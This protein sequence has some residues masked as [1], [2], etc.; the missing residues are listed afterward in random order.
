MAAIAKTITRVEQLETGDAIASG[1]VV[2]GSAVFIKN[3]ALV[4]HGVHGLVVY[5]LKDQ[6]PERLSGLM[7]VIKNAKCIDYHKAATALGL[8]HSMHSIFP[9]QSFRVDFDE[10]EIGAQSWQPKVDGLQAQFDA[11]ALVNSLDSERVQAFVDQLSAGGDA[12]QLIDAKVLVETTRATA[13]EGVN[14]S[15]IVAEVAARE[16]DVDSEAAAALGA[17]AAIQSDVDQNEADIAQEA[18]DRAAAVVAAIAAEVTARDGAISTAVAN[19]IDSAPGALD[20][21]NELAAALGDDAS[22]SASVTTS[23]AGK[24][25]QTAYL[26]AVNTAQRSL[27]NLQSLDTTTSIA[28]HLSDEQTRALAAEAVN[29]G[30][31]ATEQTRAQGVESTN[32]TA[33]SS[34]SAARATAVSGVQS[35]LDAVE[36]ILGNRTAVQIARVDASSSIQT[37]LDSKAADAVVVK[38][39]GNQTIVQNSTAAVLTLTNTNSDAPI[40]TCVGGDGEI[41]LSGGNV[42]ECDRPG[43]MYVR[44]S[45]G[46]GNVT[47][48]SRGSSKVVC[49]DKVRLKVEASAE[50]D[51]TVENAKKV[52]FVEASANGSHFISLRAPDSVTASVE[53]ELPA[54]DGSAGQ[55]LKTDGNGALSFVTAGGLSAAANESI[56]GQWTFTESVIMEEPILRTPMAPINVVY[57]FDYDENNTDDA[58]VL[59]PDVAA[60][61]YGE[62]LNSAAKSYLLLPSVCPVGTR[63][64][65]YTVTGAAS[66]NKIY[67]GTENP[68]HKLF[69]QNST[70]RHNGFDSYASNAVRTSNNNN[71]YLIE[72][73]A[74]KMVTKITSDTWTI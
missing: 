14:A 21:L 18:V 65:I 15:A 28:T 56:S 70:T 8:N 33:I 59:S 30:L 44:A 74:K 46:S 5:K 32:A 42:I 57:A 51:F 52:K 53:F 60:V 54:A 10:I 58:N 22:F 67:V 66:N 19:L 48:Q 45:D 61:L 62:T 47:I 25:G 68:E 40:L 20:T 55:V 29:A 2:S 24:Q 38:K 6:V 31:V 73:N 64:A 63:L 26:D 13:A 49:D 43:S 41:R 71:W 9:R 16:A 1:S 34:E 4:P 23:L 12:F 36:L 39:T 69:K 37:Q 7:A 35:D 17:R 27:V 50:K 72:G 3:L 11:L